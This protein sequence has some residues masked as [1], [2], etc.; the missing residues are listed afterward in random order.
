MTDTEMVEGVPTKIVMVGT[1][2]MTLHQ[3][4]SSAAHRHL[5]VYEVLDPL[6]VDFVEEYVPVAPRVRRL[7]PV[8]R[9]PIEERLTIPPRPQVVYVPVPVPRKSGRV[10]GSRGIRGR[11]GIQRNQGQKNNVRGILNSPNFKNRSVGLVSRGGRGGGRGRFA[12]GRG[13][14]TTEPKKSI[15]ELD[16]ELEEYMKKSKHPKIIV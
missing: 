14:Y 8:F 2:T 15:S 10:V 9:R 6:D 7:Q 13:R 4:A 12:A 11:G 5:Q 1:S 16:R 3:R